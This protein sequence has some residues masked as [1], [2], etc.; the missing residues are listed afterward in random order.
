[1]PLRLIIVLQPARHPKQPDRVQRHES[2]IEADKPAPESGLAEPLIELEAEG[3]REPVFVGR[4]R[5]R[6]ARHR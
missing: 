1:M 6:T 5:L 4:R 3:L 2:H